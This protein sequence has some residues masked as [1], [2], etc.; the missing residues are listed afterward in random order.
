M[1][2]FFFYRLFSPFLFL[3]I[4][5]LFAHSAVLVGDGYTEPG[6]QRERLRDGNIDREDHHASGQ[7]LLGEDLHRASSEGAA[8]QTRRRFSRDPELSRVAG[9][10]GTLCFFLSFVGYRVPY[11]FF[12][13]SKGAP[14]FFFLMIRVVFLSLVLRSIIFSMLFLLL[15]LLSSIVFSFDASSCDTNSQK[16]RI[17]RSCWVCYSGELMLPKG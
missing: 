1:C 6:Q 15:L 17:P 10:A 9:A 16:H 3:P 2:V 14:I 4:L 12:L 8:L 7:Q 13:F 11:E 5:P